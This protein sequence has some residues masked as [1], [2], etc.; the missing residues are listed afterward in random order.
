MSRSR[1]ERSP[2]PISQMAPVRGIGRQVM[3]SD[4]PRSNL[5]TAEP[6]RK[7]RSP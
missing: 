3:A 4:G 5:P 2:M 7:I 1:T 6:Q